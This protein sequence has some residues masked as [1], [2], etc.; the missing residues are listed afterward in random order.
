M[1]I[2]PYANCGES[3]GV[4]LDIPGVP[5]QSIAENTILVDASHLSG[6]FQVTVE[7][8]L[9]SK[10]VEA[11]PPSDRKNLSV[12]V[13]V[14]VLSIDGLIRTHVL[15]TN[16]KSNLYAG[17]LKLDPAVISESATLQV[18]AVRASRGKTVLGFA[19]QKG[20]RLAWSAAME[21]RLAER[22][23]PKGQYLDVRWED[24]ETS[25]EIPNGFGHAL[26]FV[27][28]NSNPPVL[29]LNKR[30]RPSLIKLLETKGHGHP[31]ALPRDVLLSS[32]RAPV[33]AT[34][35]HA[36]LTE[37]R[38]EAEDGPVDF[39][40]AF[41]GTWKGDVLEWIAPLIHSDLLPDDAVFEMCTRINDEAY[42]ADVMTRSQ[43]AVQHS[44]KLLDTY[45]SFAD[46]VFVHA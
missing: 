36:A 16:K 39:R 32:I 24:F 35:I 25:G 45:G 22:P 11:F 3:I 7:A 5:A 27:D 42:F 1:K 18:Y 33:W 28:I 26:H 41:A 44:D 15:L 31:K 43:L 8:Q 38:R 12:D 23:P 14:S 34:L 37:L 13:I 30:A 46:G 19:A 17:V 29:Y 6:P 21:V 9:P 20:A 40:V 4:S 2:L 10:M